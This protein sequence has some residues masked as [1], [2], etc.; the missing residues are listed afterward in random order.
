MM[1]CRPSRWGERQK[2]TRAE[3]VPG[4][5]I[6]SSAGNHIWRRSQKEAAAVIEL[7]YKTW[8]EEGV[9]ALASEGRRRQREWLIGAGQR[10]LAGGAQRGDHTDWHSA[11]TQRRGVHVGAVVV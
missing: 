9:G 10:G 8:Q 4:Q 6:R 1:R 3:K 11:A 2:E 7:L 5:S